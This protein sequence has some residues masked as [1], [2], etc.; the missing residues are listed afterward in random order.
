MTEPANLVI[1]WAGKEYQIEGL[2][3]DTTVLNLKQLIQEKTNVLPARQKLLNLKLKG[4]YGFISS[5]AR[6]IPGI[7]TMR[8]KVYHHS[9]LTILLLKANLRPMMHFL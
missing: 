9:L 7:I 8:V 6:N 3:A 2:Q 5:Q 4:M 1:K